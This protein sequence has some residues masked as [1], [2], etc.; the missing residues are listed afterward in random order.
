MEKTYTISKDAKK[1]YLG[2]AE[3]DD[4]TKNYNLTY[5]TKT[6][7]G[8]ARFEHYAF[9]E[10]FIFQSME[11][12]EVQMQAARAKYKWWNYKGEAYY[13]VGNIAEPN[14]SGNLVLR[15][16]E[17]LHQFSW[18]TGT[19]NSKVKTLDKVKLRT[20]EGD[21]LYYYCSFPDNITG[22]LYL[23]CG[24]K[25]KQKTDSYKQH[26]Q[27]LKIDKGLNVA[28][29]LEINFKT[30]VIPVFL[31]GMI[32]EEDN[33]DELIMV[34]RQNT[35]YIYYRISHKLEE[36]VKINFQ[37]KE[38]WEIH[39]LCHYQRDIYLFG[40]SYGRTFS[41]AKIVDNE[42]SYYKTIDLAEFQQKLKCPPNQNKTPE[43]QGAKF[44]IDDYLVT[45]EGELFITGQKWATRFNPMKKEI[46]DVYTDVLTF[47]FT[48]NG[49]LIAQY[50]L[51]PEKSNEYSKLTGNTQFLI[52]GYQDIYWILQEI[53]ASG[54]EY[55]RIITLNK[56]SAD[57]SD[58]MT[59]GG[60]QFF[61]E[62]NFPYLDSEEDYVFF[63]SDKP[64]RVIWFC[65]VRM[66]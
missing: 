18:L 63:G 8:L 29:R 64:G 11:Y 41:L 4:Q 16:I 7:K 46:R 66:D 53:I 40:P 5:V 59:L 37:G 20:E 48:D 56:K 9:D 33:I 31:A 25:D 54:Y 51:D 35:E 26:M 58:P 23:L 6:K 3:Y 34:F 45:D 47:H 49:E 14:F 22:E 32:N 28:K 50:G 62:L 13:K 24:V 61:L 60:E 42:L 27:V 44:I 15:K 36:L 12:E 10:N 39:D 52:D 17:T 2:K 19:Y 65:K 55:P 38:E 30:A 1:G 43:Y 21:K 57:I